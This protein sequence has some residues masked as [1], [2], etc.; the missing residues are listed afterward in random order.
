MVEKMKKARYT[1][2]CVKKK[3]LKLESYKNCS[4]AT[5][6]ENEIIN[7]EKMKLT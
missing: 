4:E 3:Q 5:Q 7:L 6:L 2:N 1:K